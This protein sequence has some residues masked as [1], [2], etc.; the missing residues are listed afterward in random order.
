MVRK[1]V[2]CVDDEKMVL[3]SI[4]EQLKNNFHDK[5][6]YETADNAS[7]ALELVDDLAEAG[8]DIII[9]VSD[10]LMPGIKGDELLIE[11][12][13]RYPQIVTIMLTGHADDKAV[14]NA[15]KNANLFACIHKPWEEKD[16]IGIINEAVKGA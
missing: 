5:Y 10:W 16:L 9:I 14:D 8:T 15:K 3:S 13:K 2:I 12:H 4:K 6:L 1:A 7:D 11:I